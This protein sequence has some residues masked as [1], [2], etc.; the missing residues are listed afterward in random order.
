MVWYN[1]VHASRW[2]RPWHKL[3]PTIGHRKCRYWVRNKTHVHMGLSKLEEK[4][5]TLVP[6]KS[7]EFMKVIAPGVVNLRTACGCLFSFD[8][9]LKLHK[10]KRRYLLTCEPDLWN[11]QQFLLNF[12]S[13]KSNLAD[14]VGTWSLLLARSSH[15]C[16]WYIVQRLFSD[17]YR[18]PN[19]HL[20]M[21]NQAIK[22][23]L[24]SSNPS[25]PPSF[26]P[27]PFFLWQRL[28]SRLYSF[29]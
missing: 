20:K 1:W 29:A 19:H 18:I 14:Q 5:K 25:L 7:E 28:P 6:R 26:L 27:F 15:Y 23:W 10:I 4:G 8:I 9:T 12:A 17:K 11:L 22:W 21:K 2:C 3:H 13:I 16:T 24:Y